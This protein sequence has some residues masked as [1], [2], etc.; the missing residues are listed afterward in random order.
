[1]NHQEMFGG[2]TC[3]TKAGLG[4]GTTTTLTTAN[5]QQTSIKGIS[6]SKAATSNEA[7]PTTDAVTGAAFLP[8]AANKA[9]VFT[10]CRDSSG[11]LKAIQ[12]QIV[13]NPTVGGVVHGPWYGPDLTTLAPIGSVLVKCASTASTWTFGSSNF[14]GPPTGVT[15]SFEDWAGGVPPRPRAS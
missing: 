13:D 6:Y 14:A 4:V 11:G 2:N 12:G 15:F 3:T 7:T 9:C 8:V 5:I 1:M 10:L